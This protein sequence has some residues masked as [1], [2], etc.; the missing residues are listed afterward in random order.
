MYDARM[1]LDRVSCT[2][3]RCL[4]VLACGFRRR[5]RC[6]SAR[7][8]L[9]LS[10]LLVIAAPAVSADTV[11]HVSSDAQL[12]TALRAAKPG[13]RVRI[14]A[15]TYRPGVYVSKLHGD[16]EAPIVIEG[17][18][19]TNPPV[20]QGGGEAWHLAD[21]SYV[22][23]RNIHARGQSSNGVNVDD[24]GSFDTPAHHI[25]LEKLTVTETGPRGN[26]DP[27]KLSGLDDFVVRQCLVEGWGGQAVDMVGCHRG[28]I[29]GCTFRGKRG[30]SQ[31]T[32]PQTKGGSCDVVIRNC[33]F[34]RAADRGVNIGGSTG[35]R[36]FRPLGAKYEAKNITVEGCVFVGGEAP[37]AYVGVD[38]ATVRY[39]TIYRPE[40]WVMRILQETTAP[41]FA[42]C[43]NGRFEK[44]LIV[45]CHADVS[46]L[47]NIGPNTQ[48][49]TFTFADNW[50]YCEDQPAASRPK[51]PAAET[52][53]VYGVNP[54]LSRTTDGAFKAQNDQAARYGAEGWRVALSNAER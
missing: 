42:T 7:H 16:A 48:P 22:V 31:G 38:G 39:N 41:G 50:W 6:T 5:A 18:D 44:N 30:F 27:I 34:E 28:V 25:L 17:A 21:C 49:E 35:I 43:R 29:E 9:V 14:S 8:S 45:F 4:P 10:A 52:G 47:V 33:F 40:K 1:I 20:F 24:G 32:G 26:H 37:I 11:V 36:V 19:E 54:R 51:L 15:G 46:A 23:L 13:T 3:G 2:C 53:G 12:H